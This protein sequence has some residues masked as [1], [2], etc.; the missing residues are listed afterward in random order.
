VSVCGHGSEREMFG[1]LDLEIGDGDE[2]V[3]G[4][5]TFARSMCRATRWDSSP[6]W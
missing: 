4:A 3:T 1:G 2:L 6:M 5:C